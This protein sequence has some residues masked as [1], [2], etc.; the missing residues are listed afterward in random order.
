MT[1]D[2]KPKI[3]RNRSL[4]RRVIDPS[5][6]L[7]RLAFPPPWFGCHRPRPSFSFSAKFFDLPK[8]KLGR[9]LETVLEMFLACLEKKPLFRVE[10]DGY[11]L[12][13]SLLAFADA[14][15]TPPPPEFPFAYI[16]PYPFRGDDLPLA[17]SK[18]SAKPGLDHPP[19][20]LGDGDLDNDMSSSGVPGRDENGSSV[21]GAVSPDV[22]PVSWFPDVT[23]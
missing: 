20:R 2:R 7:S 3:S 4:K 10:N 21:P 5:K 11:P 6:V 12:T 16:S 17:E 9:L 23:G 15:V 8:L 14:Q 22:A 13:S 19:P 18:G 1:I